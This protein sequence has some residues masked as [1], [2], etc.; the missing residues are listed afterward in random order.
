[1]KKRLKKLDVV[2]NECDS[3]EETEF[4][5]YRLKYGEHRAIITNEM[6]DLFGGV[7]DFLECEEYCVVY[8]WYMKRYM[9]IYGYNFYFMD[10]WIEDEYEIEPISEE[11]FKV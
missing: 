7:F 3:W 1:M 6:K 4:H 11:L 5:K 8:K 9:K 10:E 2:L